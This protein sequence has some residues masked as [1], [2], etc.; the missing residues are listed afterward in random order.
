[1]PGFEVLGKEERD[2]AMAVFE[3]SGGILFAH[4]FDA[5]R[6][7]I[8]KVR[9][10][11][12]AFAERFKI[13]HAQAVSSGS[14]AIKV[15]LDALGAGRGDEVITQAH[16][17]V[18]TIEAILL[19][20]AT[21]VIVD[22]DA[23]L[24]M[25][26]KALE[27]AITPKTKAIVPVHMM[28]VAA[29]MDPIMKVASAHGIKVMEDNAQG[30]GGSYKGKMLGTIGDVGSFSLDAGKV[31]QCGEGGM[32]VTNDQETYVLARGAHD[33][34]HEYSDVIGRGQEGAVC[35]GFNFRMSEIQAAI[36]I[37]QLGKLDMILER[38]RANKSLIKDG[39]SDLPICF[40]ALPDPD[41]D[42]SD[43][44]IFFLESRKLTARF[45]K[46]M[47]E[48]GL[49][50][51]NIPDALMWHF[52]GNW[53]HIYRRYGFY[54]NTYK[55]QWQKTDDLLQSAIAIP[56]MVKWGEA[57]IGKWVDG[58]RKIAKEIL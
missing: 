24:N 7:G 41:G 56:V 11:E 1:M 21:P 16:T 9:E 3:E 27:V 20:G 8:F 45:V 30:T 54:E 22:V 48:E 2:A 57:E 33:H 43:A 52:A 47:G 46:R 15:G 10:F 4:G 34:G 18:A 32:V 19:T 49:G 58:L 55:T 12:Q 14:A 53:K 17:F 36:G 39:L 6:N 44:V 42:V 13:S 5:I 37:V 31:I 26:P 38:N 40:R 23:S 25:C 51:K 28:G 29:D 50:T 35:S